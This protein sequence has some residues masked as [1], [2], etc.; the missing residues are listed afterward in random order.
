EIFG[1][2]SD[3]LGDL[4][5]FGSLFGSGRRRRRG[6]AGRDLRYDLEIEFDEALRGLETE[7]QIPRL[8]PCATCDGSGAASG[9]LETCATCR[10]KGQVA[11]Q[12]GFFTIARTCGTCGGAGKR[13]TK[14]CSEC[15]GEGRVRTERTITVR[16]PAGVDEGMQL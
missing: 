16:I 15:R 7:V 5:G 11:F 12:Q 14:R 2:F 6:R 9:G 3:V 8:D 4:F 13:I 10:G 1:D